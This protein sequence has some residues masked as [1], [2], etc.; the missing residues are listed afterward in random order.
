MQ[1]FK[2]VK[3]NEG[4]DREKAAQFVEL[5][6]GM[7]REEQLLQPTFKI[8]DPS[9]ELQNVKDK[10]E[11][12]LNRGATK[13]EVYYKV[14]EEK[15]AITCT[16]GKHSTA[17]V[18]LQLKETNCEKSAEPFTYPKPEEL[19]DAWKY[20]DTT[21]YRLPV[22]EKYV[23]WKVEMDAYAPPECTW[24][25]RFGTRCTKLSV[26]DVQAANQSPPED[27]R[28][29]DGRTGMRGRGVNRKLGGN[30]HHH[31]LVLRKTEQGDKQVL[32]RRIAAETGRFILPLF[33]AADIPFWHALGIRAAGDM[34][35]KVMECARTAMKD[36]FKASTK[37]YG[38]NIWAPRNTDN[39]WMDLYSHVISDEKYLE[40]IKHGADSD[41]T[42]LSI[43]KTTEDYLKDILEKMFP[44]ETAQKLMQ[45]TGSIKEK[46][47]VLQKLNVVRQTID[48]T[49]CAA[50]FYPFVPM[51]L[52]VNDFLGIVTENECDKE[53]AAQF[54]E[55][56]KGMNEAEQMV[57]PTPTI[58]DP[59]NDLQDVQDKLEQ[60]LNRGIPKSSVYYKV[61]ENKMAVTCNIGKHSTA[62]VILQLKETNCEK[63]TEPFTYPKPEELCDA[64]KYKDTTAYRLPV[65]EKYVP[66]KVEM[67]AYAP[68]ECT[69]YERFGTRCTKLSVED[70]QAANQSPPEDLRHKD[71]RTGMRG[72]GVNRKLGG[73]AHHHLLV[74]RKTEQGDKQVLIRRIAAET[75]RFILP[76]FAA[77]DIPFWHALGIRAAGDM[78]AKV[79]ECAR[80]AMKDVFKASTKLYGGN[81]WAPRNTDNA[82]MDLYSHVISDEKYL[83][84]IK[85]GADSDF[86]WLSINK[87]TEDYLK[88]ILEKMFPAETAQKLMQ[89]TGSIKE[90]LLVLQK[91]NVVRQTI[92]L[93]NCAASFY[94]FVPMGLPVNDF[95]GIVTENEC[96][97]EKAAQFVELVKGMNEAEQMVEPTPTIHDPSNDLQ[98]VQDKL[99]Q[100]LN[101]GIPKS[102]VY[103]K[104]TENKMAVTCN[105][106]KHSTAVVI[107]QLKETNCEK[108]T[109]EIGTTSGYV[110]K[111]AFTYPKPEELCTS[112]RYKHTTTYRFPVPEKYRRW[113]VEI[114]AY[115]PPECSWSPHYGGY[116]TKLSMEDVQALN[117]SIPQEFRHRDGRTGMR[118]R[119]VNQKL[120]SNIYSHLLILKKTA[121]GDKQVLMRRIAVKKGKFVMPLFPSADMPF[122]HALGKPLMDDMATEMTACA[123]KTMKSVFKVTKKLY[124]GPMWDARNTDNA[125]MDLY[126]HVISDDK[127][128]QNI[129]HG[130][131]SE[132]T[133][134]SINKTTE[135]YLKDILVKLF[136]D[137]TEELIKPTGSIK[138]KL[139]VLEDLDIVRQTIKLANCAA[140]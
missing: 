59:S 88:D 24:Y 36:V 68:P 95:L 105:I 130:A 19:C 65:P 140:L 53:K 98:D 74:L 120:G 67:D 82:W 18:I 118:G 125:W 139:L 33:A 66:W 38:G 22:P 108:S 136:P 25:E 70:V 123:Q 4:C 86:T 44:A 23:P 1:H 45:P 62:V 12:I 46:L 48:L 34:A 116:C 133:W 113:S 17:V 26:E 107:L 37:L 127:Y 134:L 11:Q 42:W 21:A 32:I 73:N 131:D 80:T 77:A 117:Q 43:N 112:W 51:G 84:N 58:H 122:W 94:P 137:E 76:L 71:G 90:K 5:V 106:G 132:F 27:L 31:L 29:K 78:A 97:K 128:L 121:Q 92:D 100:I 87:T 40:N 91:L 69:W 101:R 63:S 9:E 16:I 64:W 114:D 75:G 49:N 83:E 102:S 30:A 104:V 57:E 6:K 126:S 99:E 15:M 2:S 52:P 13:T 89:P 8:H 103:Y 110:F 35:A 61:T 119:G 93:T 79:M 85:H 10:L 7:D 47:L 50:S 115:G 41:F 60:I 54:V 129:K 14:T 39:A 81:I 28:H 72:R 3:A 135:E 109:T 138:E 20:K 124:G 56:V 96:D 55:L 111:E